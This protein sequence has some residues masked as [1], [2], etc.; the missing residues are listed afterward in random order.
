M[1]EK[2]YCRLMQKEDLEM[3][4]N[5]RM[6]PEVTRYMK[7]NPVLT[8]EK[9]FHWYERIMSSD[10]QFYW[11]I[12]IEGEPSGVIDICDIDRTQGTCSS[13]IYLVHKKMTSPKFIFN[14]Y[15]NFFDLIFFQFNL[16]RLVN[17]IKENNTG[18]IMIHKRLG[19]NLNEKGDYVEA[20]ITK[21]EWLLKK[22][23]INMDSILF[24][25]SDSMH[26]L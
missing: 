16:K 6:L 3:V 5:W 22:D 10:R 12:E 19:I 11:I 15:W 26:I 23:K 1:N 8:I 18:M 20:S 21:Q 25:K 2:V 4:M 9:Q 7:T 14:L 17:E 13:G 24:E